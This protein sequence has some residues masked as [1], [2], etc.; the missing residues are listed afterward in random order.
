MPHTILAD[1][2]W[3]GTHGIGRFSKEILTRLKNTDIIY[4]G[5]KPLSISNFFWQLLQLYYQRKRYRVY[6]TPGF[7]PIFNR[8]PRYVLTICDLIYLHTPGLKGLL[9][10]FF[11]TCLI[12][13]SLK[14]ASKIITISEYSKNAIQTW[15]NIPSDY[16]VNVGCGISDI[17]HPQGPRFSPGYPYVLHVGNASSHKNIA[18]LVT[19]FADAHID[20]TI[21]LMLT[22]P[23]THSVARLIKCKSLEHRIICTSM[24]AEDE[25]ANLYRGAIALLLPSLYEGFGLPI[26]EAMACGIPVLTS[27]VTSCPE[28]AGNAA[29][30]IDPY[31]IPSIQSG[32]E[33][34]VNNHTLRHELIT[35]GYQ[36]IK[37]Y[38]W[39]KTAAL[40]QSVLD[41]L[42]IAKD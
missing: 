19:A 12:K 1:G 14:N 40:T 38:S 16:I 7:N 33:E 41:E 17:F 23:L 37:H 4:H 32:I 15:A 3:S 30:L 42:S 31:S 36:H 9:K 18:R 5:P 39:E 25:L 8:N 20:P 6:F 24:L 27:N 11:F 26:I 2:R 13:P 28:V 22:S 10:K 29:V 35:K 21:K 34:I